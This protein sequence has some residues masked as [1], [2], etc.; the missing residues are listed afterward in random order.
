MEL[1]GNDN[2][3]AHSRLVRKVSD[4]VKNELTPRQRQL[5]AMYYVQG[6][7]MPRIARELGLNV[8]TVSRTL[9]RGRERLKR[10]LKFGAK[11]LLG[12]D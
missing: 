4:A 7:N 5:V 11:E 10:C 1:L 2:S 9:A 8:S 12:D 6:L 3:E